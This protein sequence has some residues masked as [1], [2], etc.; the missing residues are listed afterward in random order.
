[1]GWFGKVRDER[2]VSAVVV[3]VSLVALFGAAVL[4]VDAGALFTARRNM[5][6]ATDSAAL[7]G[8]RE[9][10]GHT[11]GGACP[12]DVETVVVARLV[13]QDPNAELVAC[14]LNPS[15]DKV[16]YITVDARRD[17]ELRFGGILNLGTH[18][19]FSST[20]VRYGFP[21]GAAGL[22]PIGIC[23]NNDH[24]QEWLNLKQI[25][26]DA[27]PENDAAALSSYNLLKGILPPNT[28][29]DPGLNPHPNYNG[30]FADAGV[31]HRIF[32]NRANAQGSCGDTAAEGNWG[33]LDYNCPPS[34]ANPNTDLREWVQFGYSGQVNIHEPT[35]LCTS[36]D[37]LDGCVN[38]QTGSRGVAMDDELDHLV[39]NEI[40]FYIPIFDG[41]DGG[42]ENVVFTV[43]AFVGLILRGYKSTGN[44]NDRYLDVEFYDAIIQGGCCSNTGISTGTLVTKICAVDHDADGVTEADR[45]TG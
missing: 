37:L 7:T 13:E 22:R 30:T 44:E 25:L 29:G 18:G 19:A 6:N 41:A 27:F 9:A 24:I 39:D 3:A 11:S 17:V 33:W 43:R 40:R 38:G 15:T 35:P 12:T 16:G 4:S 42:G 23:I 26:D 45:C 31:V 2:G 36:V 21:T 20:S 14:T 34:C 5:V 1:M 8:A 28:P 10:I 32:F